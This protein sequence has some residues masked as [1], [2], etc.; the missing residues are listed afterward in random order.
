M[1]GAYEF[2]FFKINANSAN[3]PVVAHDCVFLNS[4]IEHN[5]FY[6]IIRYV[7]LGFD[8]AGFW[9]TTCLRLYIKFLSTRQY[10]PPNNIKGII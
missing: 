5:L 7:V 2:T 1:T 9:E 10:N 3:V 8:Q 4:A 6:E